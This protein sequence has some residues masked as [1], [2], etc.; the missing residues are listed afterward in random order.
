MYEH[1]LHQVGTISASTAVRR[2]R[3]HAARRRVAEMRARMAAAG[4][5]R[6][7]GGYAGGN[8]GAQH[9]QSG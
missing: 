3:V 4:G 9:T 8:A 1:R 6:V 7:T 2:R 5:P